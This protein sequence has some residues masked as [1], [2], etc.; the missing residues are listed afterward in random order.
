MFLP[1]RFLMGGPV[2]RALV[3]TVLKGYTRF[4]GYLRAA[5]HIGWVSGFH[6]EG[7]LTKSAS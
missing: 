1:A 5:R 2:E 7:A 3:T 6:I 4:A